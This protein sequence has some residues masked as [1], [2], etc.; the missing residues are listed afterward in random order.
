M[1]K[2][3]KIHVFETPNALS[4]HFCKEFYDMVNN[5]KS[6]KNKINICLSGGRTPKN[7]F[8]RLATEYKNNMAWNMVH[9]FW[10]DE[11]CV[12]PYDTDSNYGMT[13]THLLDKIDIPSG[14]IHFINGEQDPYLEAQRYQNEITNN[15]EYHAGLPQFDL[16]MLGLGEDGHTASIF[17]D[18]MKKLETENIC[19]VVK[20]PDTRQFRITLTGKILKNA[21]NMFFFITGRHKAKIASLIYNGDKKSELFPATHIYPEKGN[22]YWYLDK[23]AAGLL[24]N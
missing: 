15:L 14:N 7:I 20:H 12:P 10:G 17:P 18:N 4:N 19:E 1:T 16:I 21:L 11:R 24:N 5:L 13:K 3:P 6:G 22:F 9:F 2:K 23:E 8:S